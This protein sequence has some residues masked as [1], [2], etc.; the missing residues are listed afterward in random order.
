AGPVDR[1]DD[2]EADH[3]RAK[4]GGE[5]GCEPHPM[6]ASRTQVHENKQ[7]LVGHCHGISRTPS[8]LAR[9]DHACGAS[10]M[11]LRALRPWIFVTATWVIACSYCSVASALTHFK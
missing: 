6:R 5:R 4:P 10:R 8:C 7:A 2:V 11:I 9:S 1:G 3:P